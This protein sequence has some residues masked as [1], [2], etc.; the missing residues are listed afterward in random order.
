MKKIIPFFLLCVAARSFANDFAQLTI[1][2][3]SD[4]AVYGINQPAVF[5]ITIT[6]TAAFATS[7]DKITDELP[8]GFV[9][10]S[11]HPSSQVT[12]VNSSSVP[13]YGVT[14]NIVF[15]GGISSTGDHTYD[16]P[17][18]SSLV[19]KYI[20]RTSPSPASNLVTTAQWYIGVTESGS[21]QNTVSVSASVLTLPNSL[22]SF[23]AGWIDNS[24][25]KLDWKIVN[26]SA[27]DRF[28]IEKSM[29]NSPFIPIGQLNSNDITGTSQSYSFTDPFPAR[30]NNKY[31]LKVT[32]I[33]NQ[34]KYSPVVLVTRQ[35]D[36]WS[37]AKIFPAPF[38]NELNIQIASGKKITVQLR[39]TD[40]MGNIVSSRS[41]NCVSGTS[42]ILLDE[43]ENLSPGMYTIQISGGGKTMQQKLVKR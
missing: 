2:K 13:G 8:P 36:G 19:V 18:G 30:E 42:M 38:S 17:A 43:L 37:L 5:T 41:V 35:Q 9:F 31:R 40:L 29:D 4:Q 14:G 24:R 12:A 27:G 22:L 10:Q 26:E 23:T 25:I 15:V 3:T 11:F 21:A 32:G 20:A 16:I 34:A 39:M 28:A 1:T 33:D 7:I 6:N